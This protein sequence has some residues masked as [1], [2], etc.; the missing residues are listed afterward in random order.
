MTFS[1][2]LGGARQITLSVN[3][4][5]EHVCRGLINPKGFVVRKDDHD[6]EGPNKAV[7]LA[8]VPMALAT[9]EWH[10]AVVEKQ[11]RGNSRS[12]QRRGESG[13]RRT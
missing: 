8:R 12:D 5:R 11:R 13:L 7:V 1:F 4:A 9:G 10:T 3:D 6:H 2:R